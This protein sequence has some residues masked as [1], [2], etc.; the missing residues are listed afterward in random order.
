MA[1]DHRGELLVGREPLPLE[2]LFPTREEGAGSA[3]GLVTPELAKGLFE[4]VG[5]VEPPVSLEQLGEGTA[6]VE[7]EVLAVG[8]QGIALS[9]DE[10]AVFGGEPAVLTT[11]DLVECVA[12]VAHDVELVED[13][14][15]LWCMARER[16]A[17]GLPHVHRGELDARRLLRAQ[18]GEEEIH[19]GLGAA[20][21]ADPDWTPSVEVA[22]DDA[23]VVSLPDGD[24]VHTDCPRRGQAGTGDLLL[25]VD[26]VE[27]LDRAVVEALRLGYR[28]VGHLVAECPHMH[29]EALSKARILRQPVEALYVHAATPQAVNPKPLELEVDA[30]PASRKIAGTAGAFVVAAATPVATL[31]AVG[32]FFRRRN[33]RTLAQRSPKTPISR[34][35]ASKPGSE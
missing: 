23:V 22:D 3:L 9:L 18:G 19:V 26:R 13:D 32:S 1:V 27:V 31:R 29:R 6:A 5:G 21:T 24:L 20:L 15:R 2:A 30:E 14:A 28:R 7:G 35:A 4:Q 10:A 33:T 8:E 25:H 16:G 12:E 17:E 34:E 11:A